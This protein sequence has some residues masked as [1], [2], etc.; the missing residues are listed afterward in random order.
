M[1]RCFRR[2]STFY[3][4]LKGDANA[5]NVRTRLLPALNHLKSRGLR[6]VADPVTAMLAVIGGWGKRAHYDEAW[7]PIE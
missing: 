4:I 3:T 7:F 5:I 6:C 1:P 2:K